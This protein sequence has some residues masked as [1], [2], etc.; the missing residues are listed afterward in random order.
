MKEERGWA[1][2]STGWLALATT[3]K[4]L[5]TLKE[6]RH[7]SLCRSEE[8]KYITCT[9]QENTGAR[10]GRPEPCNIC[11][12]MNSMPHP[13]AVNQDKNSCILGGRAAAA[14]LESRGTQRRLSSFNC[15]PNP[16]RDCW[17]NYLSGLMKKPVNCNV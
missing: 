15:T 17:K 4:P 7:K 13:E 16:C 3:V 14:Y 12:V 2:N 1:P 5:I 9:T 8:F 6:G 11:F 10:A